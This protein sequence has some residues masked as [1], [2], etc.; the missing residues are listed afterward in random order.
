MKNTDNTTRSVLP[1]SANYFLASASEGIYDTN[2][3]QEKLGP[4]ECKTVS[5]AHLVE[6]DVA[7]GMTW[8]HAVQ[9]RHL[10]NKI[11]ALPS[12]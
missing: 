11:P 2:I 7:I 9:Y 4:N 5:L 6:M 1:P 3:I 12:H 8:D 10:E